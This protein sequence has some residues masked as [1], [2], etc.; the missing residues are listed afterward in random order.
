MTNRLDSP[1]CRPSWRRNPHNGR[2]RRIYFAHTRKAAG[3]ALQRF[4]ER[5]AKQ[6]GWK[7]DYVEGRPVEE[8]SRN[9]TLYV[10]SLREPVARALSHY[11]Y[12][13]R[14]PCSKVVSPGQYPDFIPLPN[15]SR[16]L[17]DFIER[18]SGKLSQKECW[19]KPSK[20]IL[21]RCARNCYL[22]W[23]GANFNC[24]K[25]P[26]RSYETALQKLL[27]YNL[28]VVT[29]RMG[30]PT[31]MA[32]LM[33]MF[34]NVNT[35]I[36]S[37]TR[38]MY[39]FDESRH[40]NAKYPASYDEDTLSNLTRLNTLDSRLYNEITSCPDGTVFPAFRPRWRRRRKLSAT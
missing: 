30:D 36:L 16:T 22:R 8:P 40:W 26:E 9:D 35:T 39:C 27:K 17:E 20:R 10:T 29:E 34:G 12:E 37:Q 5:V 19:R 24:L 33:R 11:K 15:N 14:W 18:E 32:G 4:L 3:T 25:D 6:Y 1:A 13:I 38:K 2:I 7:F 23:Y 28:I 21:W 31:Y